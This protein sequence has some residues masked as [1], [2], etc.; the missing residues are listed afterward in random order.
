MRARRALH[1]GAG[2][3]HDRRAGA[4]AVARWRRR[5]RTGGVRPL[6]RRRRVLVVGRPRPARP[7]CRRPRRRRGAAGHRDRS[8]RRSRRRR[9][10]PDVGG[11]GGARRSD[12]GGSPRPGRRC[13]VVRALVDRRGHRRSRRGQ[14]PVRRPAVAAHRSR[15]RRRPPGPDAARASRGLRR[16]GVVVP[17]P[18]HRRGRSRWRRRPPPAAV[19]PGLA[20]CR[21]GAR[22]R[23]DR[24]AH[25]CLVAHL[26][27][28]RGIGGRV[29]SGGDDAVHLRPRQR[30][31]RG[32]RGDGHASRRRPPA[33]PGRARHLVRAVGRC[34]RRPSRR[35]R[36]PGHD[37][38]SLQRHLGVPRRVLRARPARARRRRPG[39]DATTGSR[40]GRAC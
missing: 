32:V 7:R 2:G 18:G 8:A 15:P 21:R 40:A 9:C 38:G 11:V 36:H 22:S 37:G 5:R 34:H 33:T 4:R 30:R 1:P 29:R 16:H 35:P 28:L 23:R 10:D 17:R 27:G 14:P 6:L 19:V 20:R 31:G 12:R 3:R 26:A 24:T 25:E 13:A 39:A